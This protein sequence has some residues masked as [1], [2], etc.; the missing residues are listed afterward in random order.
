MMDF[1]LLVKLVALNERTRQAWAHPH[2]KS[3]YKAAS[4][5]GDS[6]CDGKSRETTPGDREMNKNNY[7]QDTEPELQLYLDNRPKNMS[8]GWVFGSDRTEC[9]IYCG[10]PS[11]SKNY[12]IG[13]QTF[14]ITLNEELHVILKH[15]RDT[16][17]TQ[18]QYGPQKAGYRQAFVWIMFDSCKEIV[19]TSAWQ[20]N[21]KVVV[22]KTAQQP[23][24]CRTLHLQCRSQFLKDAKAS[25]P[26]KP[27]ISVNSG[28]IS[29]L[30]S[31]MMTQP[32]YYVR[33]D[34]RLGSGSFGEVFIVMDA[35]T[36]VPYA[37]KTFF[38]E[39]D[40]NEAEI[41][42]EQNHVSHD[43]FTL[44]CTCRQSEQSSNRRTS[45]EKDL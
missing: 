12:N 36:G 4:F 35:S 43:T 6:V 45:H 33:K 22:T 26:S 5:Q 30:A 34:Q 17:G 7:K 21:F 44:R 18:V 29:S 32:F 13:R 41:L 39:V 10:E 15:F 16:N 2:N 28:S 19:V 37:G 20:L 23:R 3:F 8:K 40:R 42:A 27:Q 9:D 25:M 14:S 31:A 38:N 1:N 24:M 11:K